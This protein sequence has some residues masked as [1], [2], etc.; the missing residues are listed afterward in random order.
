MGTK[1]FSVEAVY[2]FF[3]KKFGKKGVKEAGGTNEQ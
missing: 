1:E 2:N 3:K